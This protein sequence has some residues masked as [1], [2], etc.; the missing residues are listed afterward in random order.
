MRAALLALPV[1][2]LLSLTGC[3]A[4][5][6]AGQGTFDGQRAAAADSAAKSDVANAKVAVLAYQ[7]SG[8]T[9]LPA[10]TA[11]AEYGYVP[12]DG[13]AAV[14]ISGDETDF[15]VETIS[16]T[17]NTF[18]AEVSGTIEEGPCP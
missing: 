13:V 8:G 1:V 17:D 7:V 5:L 3:S 16:A 2:V 15:C 4:V 18:H 11:L 10:V 9:G 6:A 14:T 12:S